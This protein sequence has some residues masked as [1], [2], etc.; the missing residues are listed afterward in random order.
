MSVEQNVSDAP[1]TDL[2]NVGALNYLKKKKMK[3][4]KP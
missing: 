4:K 1:I 3:S 2:E